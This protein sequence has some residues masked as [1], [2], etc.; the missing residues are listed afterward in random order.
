M[1]KEGLVHRMKFK[2]REEDTAK[3][4]GSGDVEVLSTPS[5]IAMME[6]TARTLAQK[7]LPHEKTTVGF[8]V[9]IRHLKPAPKGA[10]IEIEAKLLKIENQRKLTF[11]VNAYWG[12]KLIGT[13]RHVRYIVDR[14]KFLKKLNP[15]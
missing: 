9:C 1:L 13:G 6:N 7:H 15:Q 3:F 8:E 10:E 12:D 14:K 4:L 2:V 5:M 11:E